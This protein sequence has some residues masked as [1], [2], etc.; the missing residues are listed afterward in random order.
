MKDGLIRGVV[1]GADTID[2]QGD[3][4]RDGL[5][6]ERARDAPA[7]HRPRGR[8][9]FGA[10]DPAHRRV[11]EDREADDIVT[12]ARDPKPISVDLR[13]VRPTRVALRRLRDARHGR[14]DAVSG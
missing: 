7:A 8:R 14:R 4:L 12:D 2:A 13:R 10:D 3:R 11:T 6:L 1:A 5:A 9:P